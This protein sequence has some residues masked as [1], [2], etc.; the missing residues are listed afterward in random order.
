MLEIIDI[1]RVSS[2]YIA[3]IFQSLGRLSMEA[4]AEKFFLI[5]KEC[6][7]FKRNHLLVFIQ[8]NPFLHVLFIPNRSFNCHE[9][10]GDDKCFKQKQGQL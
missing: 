1:T 4:S 8:C 2:L 6:G 9:C 10:K 3:G 5:L 7:M